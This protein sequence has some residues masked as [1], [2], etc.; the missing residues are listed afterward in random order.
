MTPSSS[1]SLLIHLLL[2]ERQL[3]CGHVRIQLRVH[4]LSFVQHANR[5]AERGVTRHHAQAARRQGDG[6]IRWASQ[7]KKGMIGT[8]H[9]HPNVTIDE[10]WHPKS[11]YPRADRTTN[12]TS[13]VFM[14]A[15]PLSLSSP[16]STQHTLLWSFVSESVRYPRL[17][18]PLPDKI[19]LAYRQRR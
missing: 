5:L 6:G 18:G 8:A 19:I 17:L 9:A 15:P 14:H 4:H 11:E 10:M 2:V 3:R 13:G 16:A 1:L 7:E 12:N